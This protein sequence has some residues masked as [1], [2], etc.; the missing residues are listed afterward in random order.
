MMKF[1]N[2]RSSEISLDFIVNKVDNYTTGQ[3]T[4]QA[5]ENVTKSF[6]NFAPNLIGIIREDSM[7]QDSIRNQVTTLT[8]APQSKS[9]GDLRS[10]VPEIIRICSEQEHQI[11]N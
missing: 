1:I 4:F 6:L 7:I 2:D 9:V 3:M 11:N 5:L 10:I 8:Y